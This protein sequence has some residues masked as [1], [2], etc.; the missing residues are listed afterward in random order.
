ML[1]PRSPFLYFLELLGFDV[2]YRPYCTFA[3]TISNC[4]SYLLLKLV[5]LPANYLFMSSFVMLYFFLKLKILSFI[6]ILYDE[7][8]I[9]K[10]IKLSRMSFINRKVKFS[11]QLI[12]LSRMSSLLNENLVLL[13]YFLFFKSLNFLCAF[14]GAEN[15][16][17]FHSS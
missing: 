10:N 8:L 6:L 15:A 1:H 13:F 17:K 7:N 11:F 5:K 12:K 3:Q 14:S 2:S 9:P 16:E 4:R